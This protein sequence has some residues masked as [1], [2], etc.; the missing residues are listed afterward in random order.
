MGVGGDVKICEILSHSYSN[1]YSNMKDIIKTDE[2]ERKEQEERMLGHEKKYKEILDEFRS[3]K[4]DNIWIKDTNYERCILT[5]PNF[6]FQ[7]SFLDD[8]LDYFEYNGYE[9]EYITNYDRIWDHNSFII[10][11]NL[12][13]SSYVSK[14]YEIKNCTRKKSS[15]Y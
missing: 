3:L 10:D 1:M 6:K 8:L 4:R 12:T 2:M 9:C 13:N 7:D 14:N 15:K 5:L 11:K